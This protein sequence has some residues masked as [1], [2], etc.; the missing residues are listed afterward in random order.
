MNLKSELARIPFYFWRWSDWGEA[1]MKV[2]V[3]YELVAPYALTRID[4][5]DERASAAGTGPRVVLRSDKDAGTIVLDSETTLSGVPNDAWTYVLGN[6]TAIDWVLDQ[7][8]E[9]S[10]KDPT[11]REKFNTYRFADYKDEVIDLLA[12]VITVSIETMTIVRA[13]RALPRQ[14]G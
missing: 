6:R 7:Y 10:P 11:I 9:G 8:K 2:H 13:M 3:G 12:R 4:I 14:S 5:P 1:L